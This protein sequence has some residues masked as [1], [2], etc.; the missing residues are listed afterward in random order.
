VFDI[1]ASLTAAREAQGLRL[2]DAE[3]LTCLRGKHLVALENSDFDAL[4]GRV[5][6]RAFLRTYAD[7]L[8]LDADLF[9]D[10][11]DVQVPAPDEE[12]FVVV[13]PHVRRSFP[14][15]LAAVALVAVGLVGVLVWTAFSPS[16]TKVPS[17]PP[18][19]AAKPASPPPQHHVL[20]AH[21]TSAPVRPQ[22]LV[23]RAV[24]GTCWVLVRKGGATGPVLYEGLVQPGHTL[25]FSQ[26]VW[27]RLGAPW[28]VTVK[29]GS[30]VFP[31]TSQT[32]PQNLVA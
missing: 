32:E 8:D 21:H 19:A 4:P 14:G 15:W 13:L 22:P 28:N 30:H 7:S 16:G 1:G 6:A 29:R 11:F 18:A 31:S 26:R 23:I 10:E 17:T 25:R 12:D 2:A 9:V 20:A 27:V 24:D 3:R 5:Y